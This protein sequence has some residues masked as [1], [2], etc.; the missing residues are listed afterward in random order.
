MFVRSRAAAII[1]AAARTPNL[2]AL[3]SHGT[4]FDF[5][6]AHAV[7][8]RPSHASIL[9]GTQY[10]PDIVKVRKLLGR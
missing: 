10:G 6:H 5:A 8:T 4:R 1:A 7:L 3:A 2:D 9:T